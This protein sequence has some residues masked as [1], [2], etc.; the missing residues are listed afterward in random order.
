MERHRVG[1]LRW[2]SVDRAASILPLSVKRLPVGLVPSYLRGKRYNW[3][4]GSQGGTGAN[5]YQQRGQNAPSAKTAEKLAEEYKVDART[6]KRDG[7]YAAALDALAESSPGLKIEDEAS[8]APLLSY[9][10]K[11]TSR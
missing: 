5:Q 6:I 1:S 10:L 3:E 8:V 4:K 2:Q 11:K 9:L 7:Q